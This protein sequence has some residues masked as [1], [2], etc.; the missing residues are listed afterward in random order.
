[1]DTYKR[2]DR[3]LRLYFLL[4]SKASVSIQE[5]QQ[6]FGTSKRTIYRDLKSLEL[7]GI[8][9]LSNNGSFGLL[10]GYRVQVARFTDEE[11]L[12]LLVAEKMMKQH[13]T[14]FIRQ[15][16][17]SLLVKVKSSFRY[18]QKVAFD[19]LEDKLHIIPDTKANS[20]LPTIINTILESVSERTVLQIDYVKVGDRTKQTREIE[21]AGIFFERGFWYVLAFCLTR[22]AYRNFRLDR[23]KQVKITP[24]PF[25]RKH[26][27]VQTLRAT[28][29]EVPTVEIVIECD[30]LY[31]HFLA[32]DRD[33]YGFYKE[34]ITANHV[35]MYFKC[36]A[37]PTAFVRWFLR[38]IDIAHI[39]AP[40]VLKEE[41]SDIVRN[42]S[43][44]L[45][46]S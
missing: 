27:S 41:L 10:E 46:Y 2:F 9:I 17:D 18:Q 11:M 20:Y 28:L 30:Q 26:Q 3:I 25:T 45:M 31:A 21:P 22:L 44:R 37:H 42:G 8:P 6:I 24:I 5:L 32:F 39:V 12:S 19:E 13:Q 33:A 38:F 14:N 16:F 29:A 34:E 7:V 36:A 35:K 1:M 15:Q 43:K 4:Q 23:I 40:K